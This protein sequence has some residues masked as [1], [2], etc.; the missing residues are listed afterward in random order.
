MISVSIG[1]ETRPATD[2]NP[3]WINTQINSRRNTGQN[4]CVRVS[5]DVTEIKAALSTPTC[6]Q[7]GGGRPPRPKEACVI[8]LWDKHHL[9]NANFTGGDLIGFLKEL[10]KCL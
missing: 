4:V 6:G 10:P 9:N 5:I 8:A 7:M 2:A 3:E 1:N